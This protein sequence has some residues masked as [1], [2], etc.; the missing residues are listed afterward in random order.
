MLYSS[1]VKNHILRIASKTSDF[2]DHLKFSDA[3]GERTKIDPLKRS[4]RE[5]DQ[6]LQ[7][8]RPFEYNAIRTV[9]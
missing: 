3:V 4:F 1:R 9:Y 2:M 8:S 6:S 5:L 7:D